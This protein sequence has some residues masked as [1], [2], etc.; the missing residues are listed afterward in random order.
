MNENNEIRFCKKCGAKRSPNYKYCLHCGELFHKTVNQFNHTGLIEDELLLLEEEEMHKP[1]LNYCPDCGMERIMEDVYCIECGY[2]YGKPVS[3]NNS[4]NNTHSNINYNYDGN[5]GSKVLYILAIINAVL[6][7]PVAG[8]IA[9]IMFILT[10]VDFEFV[11]YL[12]LSA[13][14]FVGSIIFLVKQ[15]KKSRN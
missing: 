9:F 10:L 1:E 6:F 14:Y 15:T 4:F 3:I 12:L 7:M 13:A 8:L 5:S 2:K 11:I